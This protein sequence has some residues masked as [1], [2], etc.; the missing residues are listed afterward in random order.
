MTN[1]RCSTDD[2]CCSSREVKWF[3]SHSRLGG[4]RDSAN[5]VILLG[6][7]FRAN[8]EG[9]EM[10]P[11]ASQALPVIYSVLRPRKVVDKAL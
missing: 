1:A 10:N 11:V 2:D 8:G 9:V 6:F 7:A 4:R 3:E 5:Q